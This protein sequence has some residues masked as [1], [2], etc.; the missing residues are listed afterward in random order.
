[1]SKRYV[2]RYTDHE[3]N[4]RHAGQYVKLGGGATDD[5]QEAQV[6]GWKKSRHDWHGLKHLYNVIPVNI[7]VAS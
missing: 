7:T 5:L 2:V 6:I 3:Q 4:G 1:M